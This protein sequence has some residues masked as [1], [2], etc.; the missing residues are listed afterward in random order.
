MWFRYYHLQTGSVKGQNVLGRFV[1]HKNSPSD[2]EPKSSLSTLVE[3]FAIEPL[4]LNRS[5]I[6]VTSVG[7]SHT[8]ISKKKLVHI[9]ICT[10]SIW[11]LCVVLILRSV[12]NFASILIVMGVCV[13]VCVDN[14]DCVGS[15]CMYVSVFTG[16]LNSYVD[17]HMANWRGSDQWKQVLYPAIVSF[18]DNPSINR[19]YTSLK[20]G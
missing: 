20:L 18:V 3:S 17:V 19:R 4:W 7:L 11:L 13:C 6:S 14:I 15:I 16:M 1:S 9:S 12:F 10:N 8:W 5:L 2:A